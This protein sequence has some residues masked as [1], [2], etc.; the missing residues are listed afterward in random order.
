MNCELLQCPFCGKKPDVSNPDTLYPTGIVWVDKKDVGRVYGTR[1]QLDYT[2]GGQCWSINCVTSSGGC[3]VEM[4][5]DSK[6]EAI[7]KWQTRV[8]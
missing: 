6:E 2:H 1:N 5:G 7:N 8:K 4:H 3:G